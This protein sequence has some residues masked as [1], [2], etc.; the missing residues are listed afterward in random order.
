VR[1]APLSFG[2]ADLRALLAI[3]SRQQRRVAAWMVTNLVNLS[4]RYTRV[5]PGLPTAQRLRP[6]ALE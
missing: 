2:I 5:E 3:A 4:A 1:V 6:N